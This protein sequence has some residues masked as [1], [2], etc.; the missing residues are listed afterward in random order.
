M[1]K[2]MFTCVTFF[3]RPAA[4]SVLISP[5]MLPYPCTCK[6]ERRQGK[7]GRA[8]SPNPTVYLL[9]SRSQDGDPS[10]AAGNTIQMALRVRSYVLRSYYHSCG[11]SNKGF[12]RVLYQQVIV[13]IL[14]FL[15][16][17]VPMWDVLGNRLNWHSFSF[18]VH[19][20]KFTESN[21]FTTGDLGIVLPH[22]VG[23]V[24]KVASQW[25]D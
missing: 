23:L 14:S 4:A 22:K 7:R 13:N 3:I 2:L 9:L 12:I 19:V 8:R 21:L 15:S 18:L 20:I 5:S 16:R 17:A 10:T 11:H 25:E 6:A 24:E 1:Q